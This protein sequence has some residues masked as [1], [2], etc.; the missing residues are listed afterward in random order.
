MLPRDTE[1]TL[2]ERV[3]T[4][5]HVAYPR[6]LELIARGQASLGSEGKVEWKLDS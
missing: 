4:A 6:A 1:S 5:E 2:Q 3:K